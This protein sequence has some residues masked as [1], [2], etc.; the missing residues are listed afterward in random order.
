PLTRCLVLLSLIVPTGLSPF[1][2]QWIF[3]PAFSIVN[4]TRIAL[5]LI[6]PPGPSW[7][8]NPH[9]AMASLILVNVWRGL[10]FYAITLLAGLQTISPELYEAAT[11][12]GAGAWGR[13]RYVP[14]P[15]MKPIIYIVTMFAALLT[16]A[17]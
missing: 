8:G 11:I 14:L 16:F 12:D 9:F 4:W 6:A 1:A 5:G 10:P 15:L 3:A 13:F 7:L 17:A 2:G